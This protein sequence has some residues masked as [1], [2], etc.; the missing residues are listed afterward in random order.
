MTATE[1]S[2]QE[3]IVEQINNAKKEFV[4]DGY[5]MSIGEVISMYRDGELEIDPDFQRSFR[6]SITQQTRLIESI[7]IG[8]P[9]PSIF[10]YQNKE[11]KWEVVDG[12][13]RLSTILRFVG[14]LQNS[15]D[16]DMHPTILQETKLLPCLRELT[17]EKLPQELQLDFKRARIEVKIIKQV[18]D[19]NAKFEVFQRL[20]ISSPLSGQEYRNALMVMMNKD[21]HKWVLE[22]AEYPAFKTCINL[23]DKWLE[24]KYDH[25]LV[26]RLFI[27]SKYTFRKGKV[28]DFLNEAIF[29]DNDK[30]LAKIEKGEFSLK[31]E[32]EKFTKTF[33]ILKRIKGDAVFQ[34]IGKG[35]QFLESYYEAIAMGVYSNIESY[36]IENENDISV[37]KEKIDKIE[38][39]ENFTEFRGGRGAS[40]EVRIKNIVP[41]G[42]EYFKKS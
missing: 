15:E 41:F 30:L 33:D 19:A 38:K 28:D 31:N 17:W 4:T 10:V 7:L 34:K 14:K 1:I 13:Q 5:T 35:R 6:W 39:Q 23:T 25:E 16:E 40:A 32:K 3:Q 27:F 42:K 11:G 20:N 22:L 24:E 9:L 37:L 29:Y 12:V 8:I 21:F 36:D 26:L 2:I 18:S